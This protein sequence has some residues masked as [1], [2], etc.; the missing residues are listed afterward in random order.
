MHL[1]FFLKETLRIAQTIALV[2][3]MGYFEN[4]ISFEEGIIYGSMIVLSILICTIIDHVYFWNSAR[5]GMQM[6]IALRG[7]LYDKV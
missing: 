2:K 4:E 7:V 5:I 6:Q 3:F 1:K